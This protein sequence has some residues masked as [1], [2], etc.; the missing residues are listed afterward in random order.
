MNNGRIPPDSKVR[1]D[2]ARIATGDDENKKGLFGQKSVSRWHHKLSQ[3]VRQLISSRTHS[4][5]L[6]ARKVTP[7]CLTRLQSLRQ[8]Q[9]KWHNSNSL[10][11]LHDLKIR[12]LT[13][14]QQ[15]IQQFQEDTSQTPSLQQL[16]GELQ[17]ELETLQNERLDRDKL[18]LAVTD[19]KIIQQTKRHPASLQKRM[20]QAGL[21][22]AELPEQFKARLI[23]RMNQKLWQPITTR[24]DTGPSA[25]FISQQIP[26]SAIRADASCTEDLF[27]NAYKGQGVCSADSTTE[28]HA[29]NL[30]TSALKTPRGQCLYQGVRHGTL[31]AYGIKDSQQRQSATENRLREALLASLSLQPE[32]LQQA[33]AHPE[34]PV[35]LTLTSTQLLTPAPRYKER[36]MV[37]EQMAAIDRLMAEQP[38]ELA[39]RG[40]D[41]QIKTIRVKARMACF[42]FG[43][44]GVAVNRSTSALLG[45]WGLSD[46]YNDQGLRQLIGY[47]KSQSTPATPRWQGHYCKNRAQLGG[48][49]EAYFKRQEQDIANQYALLGALPEQALTERQTISEKISQLMLQSQ[50]VEQ[51]AC[52]L[53]DLYRDKRH[54]HEQGD[55]YKAAARILLLTHWLNGVPLSN[56]KSGKD[57]TGMLDA[58]VKLLAA[59]IER[60]GR[61]PEPGPLQSEQD[62][63]LFQTILLQSGNLEIQEYNTDMA[64]YMTERVSAIDQRVGHPQV[65][66]AIRGGSGAV[67]S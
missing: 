44:N 47:E 25:H 36:A 29:A 51:M 41:G 4:R 46:R 13:I 61:V 45:G 55:P 59:R 3:H 57:R 21:P 9:G 52:Q 62:R 50:H 54:R 15:M 23:D 56:C 31:C 24:I 18:Q 43:V 42:N 22:A 60:D 6:K 17:Q 34:Q 26:A 53:R 2:A 10:G 28:D 16:A 67:R 66:E 35:E 11:A 64:G 12:N 14:A 40:A 37:K 8:Q 7:A 19:R 1:T 33:L 48:W 38:M 58:E 39:V 20:R 27:P 65:R 30:W 49:I 63:Q 5:T 32:R